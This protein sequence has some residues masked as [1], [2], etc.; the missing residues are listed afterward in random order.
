LGYVKETA[1]GLGVGW[2]LLIALLVIGGVTSAVIWGIGVATSGVKG[3]GDAVKINNSAE[4]RI[5]KQEKFEKLFAGVEA[6]KEK[7]ALHKGIVEANPDDKTA[8]QTLAGVQSACI[9]S[10]NQ[11]N[12][13]ARKVTSMD[14]KAAD[15]PESMTSHGCN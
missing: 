12:A 4:N 11:Y 2:I 7:V 1:K 15:L 6:N 5:E 9:S 10:V 13:E 8:K 3:A 14:W